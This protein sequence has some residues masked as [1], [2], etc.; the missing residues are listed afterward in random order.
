MSEIRERFLK[1]REKLLRRAGSGDDTALER[2]DALL[3]EMTRILGPADPDTLETEL[4][5]IEVQE[6]APHLGVWIWHGMRPLLES[7]EAEFGAASE[8]AIRA[9]FLAV[10]QDVRESLDM[11]PSEHALLDE[12]ALTVEDIAEIA[13]EAQ[14]RRARIAATLRPAVSAYAALRGA[15]EIAER[16]A[17][18]VSGCFEALLDGDRQ[19]AASLFAELADL[20]ESYDGLE[21]LTR[22]VDLTLHAPDGRDSDESLTIEDA[23]IAIAEFV[24]SIPDEDH[25]WDNFIDD[26]QTGLALAQVVALGLAEPTEAGAD[27]IEATYIAIGERLSGEDA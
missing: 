15:G 21:W 24:Q 17:Q 25:E 12:S 13:E 18:L 7:I 20:A 6:T 3:V 2:F 9:R 1:R 10:L 16:L 11:S 27:L 14:S 4:L 26:H 23:C 22:P 5:Y 19:D 8:L